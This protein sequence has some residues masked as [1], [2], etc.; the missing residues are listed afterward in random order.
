MKHKKFKFRILIQL[1]SR[2]FL[3]SDLNYKKKIREDEFFTKE[4]EWHIRIIIEQCFLV[5]R[6]K[7]IIKEIANIQETYSAKDP[8]FIIQ[9]I[10][11]KICWVD[12]GWCTGTWRRRT[13]CS[14]TTGTSSLQT[15]ASP[16]TTGMCPILFLN[17]AAVST[18]CSSVIRS[19]CGCLPCNHCSNGT[20]VVKLLKSVCR[21]P[22]AFWLWNW[23][24][25]L[26]VWFDVC[27]IFSLYDFCFHLTISSYA[28]P[29]WGNNWVFLKVKACQQNMHSP[30]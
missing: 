20:W 11:E 16:T 25:K 26:N 10:R 22:I 3:P 8:D 4:Y 30:I 24:I 18:V 28:W 14:T 6:N 23:N 5:C 13:C 17:C 21:K 29:G 27:L 7:G 15:L 1:R 2:I 19:C 12:E 9:W